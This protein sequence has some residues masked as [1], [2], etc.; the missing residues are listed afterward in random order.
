MTLGKTFQTPC[1][2]TSI[3]SCLELIAGMPADEIWEGAFGMTGWD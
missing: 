2:W 3:S 1:I